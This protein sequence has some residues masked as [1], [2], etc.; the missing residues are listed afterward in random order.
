MTDKRIVLIIVCLRKRENENFKCNNLIAGKG[1]G[2]NVL[3]VFIMAGRLKIQNYK[4]SQE[5][6]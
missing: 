6:M 4:Y 3:E 5:N 2:G 1:G